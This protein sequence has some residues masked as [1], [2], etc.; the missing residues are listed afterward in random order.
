MEVVEADLL[1]S[2]IL[3]SFEFV[4]KLLKASALLNG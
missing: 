2:G 3:E 4:E 1:V